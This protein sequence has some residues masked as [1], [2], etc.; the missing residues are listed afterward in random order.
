MLRHLQAREGETEKVIKTLKLDSL[1][2]TFIH[3]NWT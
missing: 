2:I 1:A 3:N